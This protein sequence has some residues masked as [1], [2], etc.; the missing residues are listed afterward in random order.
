MDTNSKKT[1]S[2][3]ISETSD[4]DLLN[5]MVGLQAQYRVKDS[6]NHCMCE[7]NE[8]NGDIRIVKSELE[9]RLI[10]Y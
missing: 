3:T 10:T 6:K 4:L 9:R 5:R 1:Y 7:L 2:D 8:L